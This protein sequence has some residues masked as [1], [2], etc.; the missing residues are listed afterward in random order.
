MRGTDRSRV[1]GSLHRVCPERHTPTR[2]LAFLATFV[3]HEVAIDNKGLDVRHSA[4]VLDAGGTATLAE[5]LVLRRPALVLSD[6]DAR[7]LSTVDRD[8]VERILEVELA[9]VRSLALQMQQTGRRL[10]NQHQRYLSTSHV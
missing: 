5:V 3:S 6:V 2:S 4:R 9:D 1:E 7:S 10:V 8:P